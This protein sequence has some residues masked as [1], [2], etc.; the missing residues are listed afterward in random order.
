LRADAAFARAEL[1]EALEEREVKY[2]IRLPANANLERKITELLKRPAGRPGYK[3]VTRYQSFLYQAA[4]QKRARRRETLAAQGVFTCRRLPRWSCNVD[5]EP[6]GPAS[7]KFVNLQGPVKGRQNEKLMKARGDP[8]GPGA[9]TTPHL[10]RPDIRMQPGSCHHAQDAVTQGLGPY[11]KSRLAACEGPP[12]V[13]RAD[14]GG[15]P[16]LA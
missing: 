9:I 5:G 15:D 11:W 16:A 6:V 10:Q 14:Q 2:A 7:S 12:A 3:P 4:S 13:M 8:S 1:Y